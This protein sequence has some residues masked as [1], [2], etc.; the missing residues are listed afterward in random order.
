MLQLCF[1]ISAEKLDGVI[2]MAKKLSLK[3]D[4]A[5]KL[6]DETKKKIL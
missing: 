5:K 1:I 4:L 2:L 6:V 3:N